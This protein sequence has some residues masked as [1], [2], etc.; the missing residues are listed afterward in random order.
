[1]FK[2]L[3]SGFIF[4]SMGQFTNIIVMFVLNMVLSRILNPAEIGVVALVQVFQS[5]LTSGIAPAIIQN[6][7]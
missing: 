3:R 1:M 2:D 6:K 7:S 4:T 5:I